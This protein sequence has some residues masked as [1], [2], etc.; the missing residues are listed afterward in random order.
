MNLIEKNNDVWEH[1]SDGGDWYNPTKWYTKWWGTVLEKN[2][3]VVAERQ[4]PMFIEVEYEKEEKTLGF[5][6][7]VPRYGQVVDEAGQLLFFTT[8]IE[9]DPI[10]NC[11]NWCSDNEYNYELN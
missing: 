8:S 6:E 10:T 4:F 3:E 1:L 11:E 2:G 9:G 7:W 5:I